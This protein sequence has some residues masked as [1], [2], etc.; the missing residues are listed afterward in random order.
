MEDTVISENVQTVKGLDKALAYKCLIY[1]GDLVHIDKVG[2]VNEEKK[3][4]NM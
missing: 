2:I 3:D 1:Y 4:E